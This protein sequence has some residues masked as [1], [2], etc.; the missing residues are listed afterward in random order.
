MSE[1]AQSESRSEDSAAG[2]TD[3]EIKAIAAET[4]IAAI[5]E[6]G[7]QALA[8]SAIPLTSSAVNR[9]HLRHRHAY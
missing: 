1:T 9:S 5:E 4:E 2:K 3:G 6:G 8:K 7:K